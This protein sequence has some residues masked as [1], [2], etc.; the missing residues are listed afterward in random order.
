MLFPV[1][2]A[3]NSRKSIVLYTVTLSKLPLLF[4]NFVWCFMKKYAFVFCLNS[5]YLSKANFL[6]V[7]LYS[8]SSLIHSFLNFMSSLSVSML[9]INILLRI[10]FLSLCIVL[11]CNRVPECCRS[12][13]LS[14]TDSMRK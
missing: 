14:T 13:D 1:H 8:V 6:F 12:Q 10:L 2:S 4:S 3:A 5:F 9:L 7:I 11:Y